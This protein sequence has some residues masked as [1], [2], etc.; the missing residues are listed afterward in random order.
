MA[1]YNISFESEDSKGYSFKL[2]SISLDDDNIYNYLAELYLKYIENENNYLKK[3]DELYLRLHRVII[4]DSKSYYNKY[5]LDKEKASKEKTI[6]KNFDYKWIKNNA[7]FTKYTKS[8]IANEI[9]DGCCEGNGI[10]DDDYEDDDCYTL[11]EIEEGSIN[12]EMQDVNFYTKKSI[13]NIF[14]KK[15]NN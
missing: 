8:V 14:K 5:K 13:E 9:M 3:L 6:D 1:I 2:C 11:D 15:M 10:D 7:D 12:V 4:T